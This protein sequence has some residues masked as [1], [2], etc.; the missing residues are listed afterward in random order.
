MSGR[1]MVSC[2]TDPVYIPIQQR[3]KNMQHLSLPGLSKKV[4]PIVQGTVMLSSENEAEGFALL[5]AVFE[6]G[7]NTFDTAH[8]Y[9]NG[10]VERVLGRWLNGRGVRDQ[11]VILDKGA[12]HNADRR[13]VT[14]FDITADIHDS[15]ARLQTDYID[16][17]A[18]HRD[19][20]NAPV[21]PI[22]RA[23]HEHAEAG[24][25]HIF[26]GSNWRT[27]RLEAANA[28]AEDNQLTPFT[29]SSPHFSLA[30]QIEPPWDDCVSI[31]G[32]GA[33]EQTWYRQYRMPVFCW[34]S[35]AGGW[36]SGRVTRE[37]IQDNTDELFV[38][39][40]NSEANWE[41]LE[42]A[43]QLGATIG[44]TPAQVAL[45]YVLHQPFETFPL[46]A[47]YT[48]E[49]FAACAAALDIALTENDIAWL[50]LRAAER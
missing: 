47:A 28:Y 15:L 34:S 27:E 39:C 10:D 40:Y 30:E 9:G 1:A 45:A 2:P 42:R 49:E 35:L 36:F 43:K 38:R 23:L 46:V 14:P 13:R 33:S 50:D 32:P 4:S 17:Y 18:L 25:I 12:H 37:T 7:C 19:D 41:R 20:P 11:V 6:M 31:T 8:V 29:F 5:D 16:M 48:P 22:V 3:K 44:A 26:G 21:G 24:R